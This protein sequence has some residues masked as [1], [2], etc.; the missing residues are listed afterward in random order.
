M[1]NI[2]TFHNTIAF[3]RDSDERE[4]ARA[5]IRRIMGISPTPQQWELLETDAAGI[6]ALAVA[7]RDPSTITATI[8]SYPRQLTDGTVSVL[9]G[10]LCAESRETM[11]KRGAAVEA[12]LWTGAHYLTQHGWW[13]LTGLFGKRLYDA[14]YRK[15][16]GL[17]AVELQLIEC[18]RL[19][20]RSLA[21]D[22]AQR[23]PN[24]PKWLIG[25]RLGIDDTITAP[26]V[27]YFT[28]QGTVV[29]VETHFSLCLR[30]TVWPLLQW[31]AS[32]R[33][34]YDLF[35]TFITLRITLSGW[36]RHPIT[37][38]RLFHLF[39]TLGSTSAVMEK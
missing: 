5:L 15:L 17:G 34:K 7:R 3:V 4:A 27:L 1:R 28:A 2:E 21:V 32:G 23:I 31:C 13:L 18:R 36:W 30:G 38:L 9:I 8:A 22:L 24:P 33:G 16:L 39:W 10:Q 6:S 20:I 37:A 19:D 14:Y 12:V 25:R 11:R 26:M 29:E 35:K